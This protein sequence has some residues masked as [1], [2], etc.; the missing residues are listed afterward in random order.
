MKET[1]L[2]LLVSNNPEKPKETALY[3]NALAIVKAILKQSTASP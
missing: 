2:T 3:T 1:Y